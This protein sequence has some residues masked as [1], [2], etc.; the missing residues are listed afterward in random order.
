M[1]LTCSSFDDIEKKYAGQ[2]YGVFKADV[3]ERV[4]ESLA[5]IQKCY[6]EIIDD[7]TYLNNT[8]RNGAERAIARSELV[9][10][11]VHDA[12]GFIPSQV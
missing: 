2:G 10:K 1:G 3:A 7:K 11:R 5:P 9:L 6:H 4:V 8:L 12:I